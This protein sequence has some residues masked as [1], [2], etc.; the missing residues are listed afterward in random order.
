M[1]LELSRFA[2]YRNSPTDSKRKRECIELTGVLSWLEQFI[3]LEHVELGQDPPDFV[4]HHEG[5][6]MGI[7]LTDLNPKCFESGGNPKRAEFD[8]WQK[9]FKAEREQRHEFDWGEFTLKDSLA[10]FESQ[11]AGKAQKTKNWRGAFSEKWLV[12]NIGK[13]C[14]LACLLAQ[15][16]NDIPGKE[17]EAADHDAKA[18]HAVFSITRRTNPFD[19]VILFSGPAHLVFPA[20]DA[21][22]HKFPTPSAVAL[23]RGAAAS[24]KYLDWKSNMTS[25]VEH[26]RLA[27]VRGAREAP[28]RK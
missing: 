23:A 17:A 13:G 4:F 26:P 16:R 20:N 2:I 22:P 21:N 15:E 10:A 6:L 19:Y 7:E 3:T 5:K 12:M 1:K 14:P 9:V 27:E 24:D 8:K 11:F 28:Y 18:T 25:I